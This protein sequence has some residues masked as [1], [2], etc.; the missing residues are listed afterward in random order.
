MFA[1]VRPDPRTAKKFAHHDG[2]CLYILEYD[3]GARAS[4]WDDVWTGPAL[5]GAIAVVGSL[6]VGVPLGLGLAALAGR[7]LG[8]LFVLPPPLL[9]VPALPLVALAL[10]VAGAAALA[11]GAALVA[12]DRRAVP[13][14]LREP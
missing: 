11:L 5:E 7:V 1:S 9:A 6:A 14:V 2:I 4:S 12:V 10:L 13:A 8:L 3:N